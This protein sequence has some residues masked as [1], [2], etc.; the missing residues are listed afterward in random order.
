VRVLACQVFL[1]QLPKPQG[2]LTNSPESAPGPCGPRRPAPGAPGPRVSHIHQL[3]K[4]QPT[5]DP[6]FGK[7]WMSPVVQ[8]TSRRLWVLAMRLRNVAV[9]WV[10]P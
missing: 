8:L 6:C 10:Q 2:V 1:E 3:G 5:T 4:T 7:C 9:A